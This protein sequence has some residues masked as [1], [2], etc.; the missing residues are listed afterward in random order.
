MVFELLIFILIVYRICKTKGLLRLSLVTRRNIINII[1]HD[2]AMYFGAMM[3]V[4]IPNILTYYSGSVAIR[5]SLSTLTSC[6][7]V[8][9]ISRLMLNLHKSINTGI[10]SIPAQ[11]E[12][13][14]LAVFTTRINLQSAI[15][16]YHW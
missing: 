5:G 1:F 16:T 2:G 6:L 7:S 8:T 9:L 13:P 15:S 14:S 11:D 10:C 4:N 3:L 12:G